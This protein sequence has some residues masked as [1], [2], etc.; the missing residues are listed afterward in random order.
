MNILFLSELFYP[1]GGGAELATYLYAKLLSRKAGF[2]IAV[3]TNRF[4]GET[5]VSKSENL[6]VYRLPLFD[7]TDNVKY[8]ILRRFDVLVSVFLRKLVKW[9]DVVYVPR[10]WFSAI[11]LAK[12]CGKPV[13]THIHDYIP[14]CPLAILYDSINNTVCDRNGAC[15]SRCIYLAESKK[16]GLVRSAG[17]IFLNLTAWPLLRR[18]VASSDAIVCVSKAQRNLLA[19]HALSLATKAQVIYNPLPQLSPLDMVGDDFGYLGGP[20]VQK[21]FDVLCRAL[22]F[23]NDHS[24]LVHAT[25]FSQTQTAI[26]RSSKKLGIVFYR[27]F[28]LRE[29]LMLYR[30]IR[31]VL[32]PS[33]VA[34]P[35]PYVVLEAILRSRVVVASKIGGIPE[36]VEGCKGAFLFEAGNYEQLGEKMLY[37]KDLSREAIA[38][39]GLRNRKIINRKFSNEKTS[40]KFIR[41]MNMVSH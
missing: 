11:P 38:D 10:F 33:I 36:L 28:G 17:S 1:H 13:V 24:L 30:K 31:A 12:A 21:G 25:G 15:S 23:S 5:E 39:W 32:V 18:F 35:S 29:V 2:N 3:V 40:R 4:D 14:I 20:S 37:V 22:A 7:G 27:R 6:T 9:S 19:R 41:L 26:A 34:E 8:S 16:R